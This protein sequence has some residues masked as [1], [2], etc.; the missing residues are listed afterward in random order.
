MAVSKYNIHPRG[1]NPQSRRDSIGRVVG[2][3]LDLCYQ[4]SAPFTT[5]MRRRRRPNVGD[6]VYLHSVCDLSW[7]DVDTITNPSGRGVGVGEN[8]RAQ[9]VTDMLVAGTGGPSRHMMGAQNLPDALAAQ[10]L[11]DP[12]GFK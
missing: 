9:I 5:L 4:R 2:M 10:T 8:G 3:C 6:A 11:R 1:W 7:R 12:D